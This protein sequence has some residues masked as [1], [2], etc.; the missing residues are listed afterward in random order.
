MPFNLIN[1][2]VSLNGFQFRLSS[3]FR[4]KDRYG[5]NSLGV[6]FSMDIYIYVYLMSCKSLPLSLLFPHKSIERLC[7]SLTSFVLQLTIVYWIIESISFIS[8]F[9]AAMTNECSYTLNRRFLIQL[10]SLVWLRMMSSFVDSFFSVCRRV[11]YCI[12][13]TSE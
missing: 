12:H 9:F 8:L 1:T 5:T 2:Q 7:L 6:I 3:E 4:R 13:L 11:V 10:S